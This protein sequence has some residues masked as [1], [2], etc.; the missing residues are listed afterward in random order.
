MTDTDSIRLEAASAQAEAEAEAAADAKS[1]PPA[2]KRTPGKLPPMGNASKDSQEAA[3][4]M[5]SKLRR[6]R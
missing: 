5:L 2:G 6:R 3:A 1:K 4:A